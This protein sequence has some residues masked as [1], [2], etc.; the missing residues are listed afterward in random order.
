MEEGTLFQ[1][2]DSRGLEILQF[3]ME[4]VKVKPQK[5]IDSKGQQTRNP[6]YDFVHV[7]RAWTE[8]TLT[9]LWIA[10]VWPGQVDHWSH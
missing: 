6:G 1:A 10:N 8:V 9:L 4:E 2:R 7:A 5:S 3:F